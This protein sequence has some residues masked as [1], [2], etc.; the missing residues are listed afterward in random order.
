MNGMDATTGKPISGDAHLAQSVVDILTTPIG[1]RI[2]L[3]DYGSL[4]PSLID[5]PI[6]AATPML[7]RAA[8]VL[9][10]RQW[11]P[12]LSIARVRL[13]G[14]PALGQLT[15]QI[16]GQRADTGRPATLSPITF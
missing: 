16:S 15:I 7:I 8:T 4:I 2:M 10:I 3:R 11:E 5:A 13:F 14:A 9:A 1:S 12:R 6:N